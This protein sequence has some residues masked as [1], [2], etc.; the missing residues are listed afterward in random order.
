MLERLIQLSSKEGKWNGGFAPYG[1]NLQNGQLVICEEEAEVV[2]LIFD[3]YVHTQMGTHSAIKW[4]NEN[5][6]TKIQRQTGTL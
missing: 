2:R 5:G 6:Y 4:L 1:Y 3:K